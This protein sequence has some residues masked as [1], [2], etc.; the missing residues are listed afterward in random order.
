MG[1]PPRVLNWRLAARLE[2]VAE[3]LAAHPRSL[4][5]ALKRGLIFNDL[6]ARMN[7][8]PSRTLLELEFF[9]NLL[10]PCPSRTS[11]VLPE[12]KLAHSNR[13][14]FIRLPRL[15][16]WFYALQIGCRGYLKRL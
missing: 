16:W 8:C 12:P 1:H 2:E 9:R 3:K 11:R 13:S 10:K 7:S 4:P 14:V 5:Q 15:L 6:T